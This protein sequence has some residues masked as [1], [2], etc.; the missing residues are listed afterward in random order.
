[1]ALA[2]VYCVEIYQLFS[3]SQTGEKID[4]FRGV[5]VK[6]EAEHQQ[7]PLK[8]A[9]TIKVLSLDA[10]SFFFFSSYSHPPP[11]VWCKVL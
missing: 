8:I 7:L 3:L 4:L 2:L 11:L 1:M 6:E 9:R 5:T 10:F